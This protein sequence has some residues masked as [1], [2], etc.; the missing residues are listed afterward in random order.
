MELFFPIFVIF[1]S[2]LRYMVVIFFI[3][4]A[5][6]GGNPFLRVVHVF[7]NVLALS[8]PGFLSAGMDTFAGLGA[9]PAFGIAF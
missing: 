6:T 5:E 3:F 9:D 4:S 8:S 7:L 1:F 2:L